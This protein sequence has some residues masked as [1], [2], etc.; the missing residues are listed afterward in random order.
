MA[1]SPIA[2][3]KSKAQ[4][5]SRSGVVRMEWTGVSGRGN[6]GKPKP[7]ESA[8]NTVLRCGRAT[9]YADYLVPSAARRPTG[10]CPALL[11]VT[12]CRRVDPHSRAQQ[13]CTRGTA[14]V[15]TTV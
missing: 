9:K 5:R 6:A 13:D 4:R 11:G 8:E 12:R 2:S 7:S 14:D 15:L 3:R 10:P 1:L